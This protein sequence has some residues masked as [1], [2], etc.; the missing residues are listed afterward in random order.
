M[1]WKKPGVWDD[2]HA[3]FERFFELNPEAAG[4]RHNY[5]R[6]AYQ[7]GKY[8]AFLEQ[9]ALFP[10]TNFVYFGGKDQ[11]DNMVKTASTRAA[12]K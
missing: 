3:S 9:V 10:N 7:C 2:L 4:A 1:Y 12:K 8:D 11:F 6:A 5:A